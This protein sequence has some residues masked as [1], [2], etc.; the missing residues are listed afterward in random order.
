MFNSLSLFCCSNEDKHI[1]YDSIESFQKTHH[2]AI[3]ASHS[4]LFINHFSSI[5]MLDISLRYSLR[6]DTNNSGENCS[7]ILVNHSMSEKNI[8]IS[9]FSQSKL[10]L[11]SPD[12]ISC[13]TS[14]DTYSESALFNLVLCLF[15]IKY[16]ATFETVKESIKAINNSIG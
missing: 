11:Q 2:N 10:T 12:N 6:K 8:Q 5:I 13:A 9:L 4:Y 16:L 7:D 1:W 3:I 15:S 14:S